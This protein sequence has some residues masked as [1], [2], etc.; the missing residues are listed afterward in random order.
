MIETVVVVEAV[1]AG[2]VRWVDIDRL[3]FASETFG[4]RGER[5]QVVALDD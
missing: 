2:V 1:V 3:Y 5:E 4:E